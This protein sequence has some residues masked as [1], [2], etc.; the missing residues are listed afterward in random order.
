MGGRGDFAAITSVSVRRWLDPLPHRGRVEERE[1]RFFSHKHFNPHKV[2][3]A[4]A[5][6]QWFGVSPILPASVCGWP[7]AGGRPVAGYFLHCAMK[8]VTKEAAPRF[9]RNPEAASL[10]RAAKELALWAQTA[11]AGLRLP[12]P[13]PAASAPSEGGKPADDAMRH[14]GQARFVFVGP[15]SHFS[16]GS[17]I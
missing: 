13:R 8:K 11:F 10:D 16:P 17:T 1:Q 9:R 15:R 14:G 7:L 3:P 2:I 12:R 5:G 4:Q 6:I